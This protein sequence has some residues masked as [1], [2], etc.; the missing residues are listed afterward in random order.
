MKSKLAGIGAMLILYSGC[1][2]PITQIQIQIPKDLIEL[3]LL[4]E[5]NIER[6]IA[7]TVLL[8]TKNYYQQ[9]SANFTNTQ[10]GMGVAYDKSILTVEHVVSHPHPLFIHSGKLFVPINIEPERTETKLIDNPSILE[11]IVDNEDSD[12]AVLKL[13]STYEG[14]RFPFGL[15][16]RTYLGQEVL[17]I[18]NPYLRG[19]T[20]R[21]G[22]VSSLDGNKVWI[23]A[24]ATPGDSGTAVVDRLTFQLIGLTSGVWYHE[25]MK[26]KSFTYAVPIDKFKPH[27]K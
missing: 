20:I 15:S 12:M 18:G 16:D 21:D 13:P 2:K 10:Y 8:E 19:F 1:A 7:S 9:G 25:Q 23:S 26:D 6:V 17:L 5:E 4:Q 14:Q 3:R 22:I 24:M 27:L 11:R